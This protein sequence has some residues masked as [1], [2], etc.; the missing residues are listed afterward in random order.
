MKPQCAASFT[1]EVD[2][3]VWESGLVTCTYLMCEKDQGVYLW[4]QEKMLEGVSRESGKAW[5]V[6]KADSGHSAWLTEIPLI[7]RLIE[8]GA[9]EM[10]RWI[11]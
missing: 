10:S 2:S 6:E 4:L 11:Q 8:R 5:V 9:G 3:V 7:L 1:S